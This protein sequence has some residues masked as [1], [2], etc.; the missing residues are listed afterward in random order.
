[1]RKRE[2]VEVVGHRQVRDA[3]VDVRPGE[4]GPVRQRPCG[5]ECLQVPDRLVGRPARLGD[6][7]EGRVA[8][9]VQRVGEVAEVQ[10][11][12]E[13]SVT[14]RWFRSLTMRSPRTLLPETPSTF[15]PKGWNPI[16]C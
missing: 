9:L 15:Q 4:I 6:E 2:V 3:A 14:T 13:S 7:G 11:A 10:L 1:L 12:F 5:V 8:E 16:A